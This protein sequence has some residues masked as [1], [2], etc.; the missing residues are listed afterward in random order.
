MP[1]NAH[2]YSKNGKVI[3]ASDCTIKD[4]GKKFFCSTE[5]CYAEMILV[6]A[7]NPLAA[8]F[9]SKDK[10][11]HIS[12]MCIKNSIQFYDSDYD[13]SRF[14]LDFAFES[15]IGGKQRIKRGTTGSSTGNVGGGKHLRIHTLP[16][17]YAMCISK[18]KK[19]KYNGIL[20]DDLLVDDE[21]YEKYSKGIFGKKIVETSKYHKVKDEFAFIM[22]YPA[23]NFGKDSWVKIIFKDEDMFWE[24]YK[25]LKESKHIEPIII[26]GN[27]DKADEEAEYH[28]QCIIQNRNQIYY[29]IEQ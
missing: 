17:L 2:I 21:N 19:D 12:N 18:S 24:Q 11:K 6:N 7:A 15:M 25:K 29:A 13:E 8:Y 3:A 1:N 9:R 23:E 4:V 10:S 22:N 20:I 16:K 5:K 14:D 28:S 26:A 27:W